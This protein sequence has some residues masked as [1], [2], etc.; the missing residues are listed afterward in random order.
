VRNWVL[1]FLLL[2]VAGLILSVLTHLASWFGSTWPLGQQAILLH[3]GVFVVF[4]PAGIAAG[5]FGPRRHDFWKTA[6]RGCP[7]WMRTAVYGFFG[8]AVVNFAWFLFSTI[9]H[10]N[11]GHGPITP[12]MLRGFSGHWMAFYAMSAGV[13]YSAWVT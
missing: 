13:L 6:L 12:E 5:G 2:A 7:A 8:Y 3:F 1:P 11:S 9:H 4:F 10:G